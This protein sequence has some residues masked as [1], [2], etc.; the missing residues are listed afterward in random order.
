MDARG[1]TDDTETVNIFV[2]IAE[3]RKLMLIDHFC[4]ISCIN[5]TVLIDVS[6]QIKYCIL[7]CLFLDCFLKILGT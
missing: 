1:K 6:V 7:E 2:N 5:L 4:L 3:Q